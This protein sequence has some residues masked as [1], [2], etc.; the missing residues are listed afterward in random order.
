VARIDDHVGFQRQNWRGVA[1]ALGSFNGSRA[2][3]ADPGTY[4]TAPLALYLPGVAW[5][6]SAQT[7]QYGPTPVTVDEVDVVG[8]EGQQLVSRPPDG[9]SL[10]S[11]RVVDG[12]YLVVRFRLALPWHLA[13]SA[14]ATRAQQL[15]SPAT[16][17]AAVLIQHS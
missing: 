17:S 8:Q 2:I 7:P 15:L 10:L 4:A 1:S 3:I 12:T 9:A 5:T 14:I 6:G 11:M 13:P 16:P